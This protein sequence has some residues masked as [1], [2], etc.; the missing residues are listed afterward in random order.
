MP[1]LWVAPMKSVQVAGCG[2][3]VIG[4]LFMNVLNHIG[5]FLVQVTNTRFV[6]WAEAKAALSEAWA[7][8]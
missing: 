5:A 1:G 7:K 4:G 8:K 2:C 6:T 3:R